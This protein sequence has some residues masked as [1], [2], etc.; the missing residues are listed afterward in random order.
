MKTFATALTL[1]LATS[2]FA[3]AFADYSCG[4]RSA[5]VNHL[6]ERFGEKI[7]AAGVGRN[8]QSV[9]E[10]FANDL[11]TWTILI[12]RTN[13]IACITA[14]GENWTEVQQLMGEPS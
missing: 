12:T 13:G 6:K 7:I 10:L 14:N 2:L 3:P 1:F 4:P 8:G 5:A 9:I 11:G